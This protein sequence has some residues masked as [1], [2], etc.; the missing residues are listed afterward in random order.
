MVGQQLS[1]FDFLTPEKPPKPYT[2]EMMVAR[3]KAMAEKNSMIDTFKTNIAIYFATP[4]QALNWLHDD[5]D[6]KKYFKT[7]VKVYNSFTYHIYNEDLIVMSY[8]P[9]D[10]YH[11]LLIPS[12]D[13]LIVELPPITNLKDELC[14]PAC[15]IDWYYKDGTRADMSDY[16]NRKEHEIITDEIRHPVDDKVMSFSEWRRD[17]REYYFFNIIKLH[18]FGKGGR[19]SKYKYDTF[20][21]YTWT[22][23]DMANYYKES[24]I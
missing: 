15:A 19:V 5:E 20:T 7:F 13:N 12:N 17:R 14:A 21:N 23:W 9:C 24:K 10:A 22:L 11:V 6:I 2:H 3:L 1:L 18:K 8:K 4:S 16:L